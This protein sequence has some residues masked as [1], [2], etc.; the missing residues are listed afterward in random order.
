MNELVQQIL[1]SE[2]ADQQLEF[3]LTTGE[4]LVLDAEHCWVTE[5]EIFRM[6]A[7]PRRCSLDPDKYD[8]ED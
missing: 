6:H 8:G 4:L 7:I 2:D 5:E 3:H 1:Q